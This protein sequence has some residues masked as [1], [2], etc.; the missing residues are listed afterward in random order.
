M[1]ESLKEAPKKTVGMKQTLK[2]VQGGAA[3]EVF[4]AEDVSDYISQKVR[5]QCK[6]NNIRITMVD[7][8]SELGKACGIAVGA[9]TAAILKED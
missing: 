6:S 5:E 3:L 8:M 9:A 4:L 1:L 2:A 7:S